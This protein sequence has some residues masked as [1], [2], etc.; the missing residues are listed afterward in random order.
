MSIFWKEAKLIFSQP[1][2]MAGRRKVQVSYW[3]LFYLFDLISRGGCHE[4]LPYKDIFSI[5]ITS[6]IINFIFFQVSFVIRD[7]GERCHRA[8]VNSLQYDH[9][10]KRL[11]SAGRDSIIRWA[12]MTSS[13][14]FL[15]DHSGSGM[16]RIPR[17]LTSSPWSTTQTGWMTS[18]SAAEVRVINTE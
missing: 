10:L 3:F 14:E 2:K 13:S 16:C 9:N 17:T 8:G 12:E 18:S 7:E 6:G 4:T 5:F 1:R 15:H 11:Y